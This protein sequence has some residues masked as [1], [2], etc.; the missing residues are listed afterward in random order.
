[1]SMTKRILSCAMTLTA[2]TLAACSGGS[3][4]PPGPPGPPPPEA[5]TITGLADVTLPQDTVS[6]PIPFAIADADSTLDGIAVTA[7]S[8]DES[9][10]PAEGIV[11]DGSE[12]ARTIRV[13]PAEEAIGTA[14]IT[15]RA[16]DG[17]GLYSESSFRVQVDGVFVSFRDK[18]K[19]TY[20][21]EENAD[22]RTLFGF[23]LTQDADDDPAAFDEFL[24]E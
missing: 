22:P 5:P 1:M 16:T 4:A 3:G 23:T 10:I 13:A 17:E 19:E 18:L 2:C 20:A 21:D 14:V 12:G 24:V 11:L 7:R 9:I 6:A 15:V 8:S